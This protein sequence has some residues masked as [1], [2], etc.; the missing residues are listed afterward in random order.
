MCIPSEGKLKSIE[1]DLY[2]PSSPSSEA[3]L[4]LSSSLP[5]SFR[6][7][8]SLPL[9][10]HRPRSS[11]VTSASAPVFCRRGPR[12]RLSIS[13]QTRHISLRWAD[14]RP[15]HPLLPRR[16]PILARHPSPKPFRGSRG[17]IF[18]LSVVCT[19]PSWNSDEVP[20]QRS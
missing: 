5:P 6:S 13:R 9:S 1:I 7:C 11:L 20:R 12:L 3:D 10:S 16:I 18:V 19:C 2:S 14:S 17:S 4:P 15:T 8:P